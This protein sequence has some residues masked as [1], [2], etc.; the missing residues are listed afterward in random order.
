[1]L[2]FNA[3]DLR[4]LSSSSSPSDSE[5]S[6]SHRD[7]STPGTTPEG[8]SIGSRSGSPEPNHLSS[9][10]QTSRDRTSTSTS[11][12]RQSTSSDGVPAIPHRALSHT[13]ATH[14]ALARKRSVSR[15]APPNTVPN[16]YDQAV[17]EAADAPHPFSRELEQVNELA[18]EFG[19]RES[20]VD[21]EEQ[22]L[23]QKGLKKFMAQDYVLEIQGLFGGV[24][25]DRLMPLGSAWI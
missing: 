5:A 6:H 11:S 24:F 1:M 10:F 16:L 7:F 2:S 19:V 3:P 4:S 18:E 9:Y 17:A 20:L 12:T 25:E 14:K 21:E 23:M 8:S 13:A 22:I 15:A